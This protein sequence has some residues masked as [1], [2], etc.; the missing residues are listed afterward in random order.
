MGHRKLMSGI[1]GIPAAVQHTSCVCAFALLKHRVPSQ[2]LAL[3]ASEPGMTHRQ[4]Q[5]YTRRWTQLVSGLTTCWLQY[6]QSLAER[7]RG[8]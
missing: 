2:F 4:G 5:L 7:P 6:S 1:Q 3:L 8:V